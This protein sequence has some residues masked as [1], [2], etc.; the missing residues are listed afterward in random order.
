M[1]LSS[2]NQNNL[3]GDF[4]KMKNT[5]NVILVI[6]LIL[7]VTA[8]N[9]SIG[10]SNIVSKLENKTV[11][12]VEDA[13]SNSKLSDNLSI[14][15][16]SIY[17]SSFEESSDTSINSDSIVRNPLSTSV[18]SNILSKSISKSTS[19]TSKVQA[20]PTP[21]L[22]V[23]SSR[24]KLNDIGSH[25]WG[26]YLYF[27][28]PISYFDGFYKKKINSNEEVIK[29][30]DES[31]P[32][33]DVLD[34]VIYY[35]TQNGKLYRMDTDGNNKKLL[36]E[37]YYVIKVAG[38]WIFAGH[39][40]QLYMLRTDGSK[41]IRLSPNT[42][43]DYRENYE[44]LGFD[45]GFCYYSAQNQW[46]SA[47][48]TKPGVISISYASADKRVDYRSNNPFSEDTD[49]YFLGHTNIKQIIYGK[50]YFDMN[51]CSYINLSNKTIKEIPVQ[52]YYGGGNFFD[53]YLFYIYQKTIQS[54]SFEYYRFQ[55]LT[56]GNCID[57]ARDYNISYTIICQDLNN[58]DV[59]V[60]CRNSSNG[61]MEVV[62]YN[63]DNTKQTVFKYDRNGNFTS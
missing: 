37:S 62:R 29:L 28:P 5:C 16:S 58:N 14:D 46:Y 56:N 15:S 3:W 40:S 50:A 26:G 34:N 11:G 41:I 44:V 9:K 30:A 63:P 53:N 33:F 61:I 39:D 17:G 19:T 27:V 21:K 8:C 10:K 1:L 7:S 32:L 36:Y 55:N 4:Y 43:H 47:N 20:T 59:Y 23:L 35:T 12:S 24:E 49:D 57:F 51:P 48:Q 31:Y 13:D 6:C 38:L 52:G 45:H 2:K 60:D 42:A 54:N 25:V 18:T 22:Q